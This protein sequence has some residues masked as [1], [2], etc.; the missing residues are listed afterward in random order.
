MKNQQILRSTHRYVANTYAR[1]PIALVQG[2]GARVWDADGKEYIDFVAGIAVNSLGHNHPAV[3]RA[4]ERQARILIHVSN[5]YHI[6]PQSELARELCRH[7][8]A[9][10]VF[11]CNSGAEATVRSA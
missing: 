6:G 7:S 11:F 2:K 3:V 5:L 8:F 9:D 4:I 10:R 1:F